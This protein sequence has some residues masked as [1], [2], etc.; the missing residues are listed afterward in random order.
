M[1]TVTGR[2]HFFRLPIEPRR[3]FIAGNAHVNT[4]Q[5]LPMA[6]PPKEKLNVLFAHV[7]YQFAEPFAAR[8]SGIACEI[9]TSAAELEAKIG[10][11]DVLSISGLWRN[12]LIALAPRLKLIQ[13]ISAGTDQYGKEQLKAAGIRLASAHGVNANAVAEHAISLV[14]SLS[15]QLHL[16]RDKQAKREWR[17]MQGNRSIREDEVQGKTV[18][19]VG[20]GRIGARLAE[21]CK[22]FGMTVLAT[23]RNPAT[24][25]GA[26]DELHANS[27]LH[28]LLPRADYV[29]LTCPLTPETEKL[30]G[31]RELAAM[32]PSAS[33]VNVARGKV[34]DEPALIAALE[35][36]QIA[37]AGIDV[38]VE[39]PL[40]AASPLWAMPHVIVTPHTGGETRRYEDR[41]IDLLLENV[42][43][44]GRGDAALVNQIV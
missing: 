7:A 44:L 35:K 20:M 9:A 12:E 43:R 37:G 18:L 42:A 29:V 13:S 6:F 23:K 34:C 28:T 10:S 19:I 16:L 26:A 39:E 14:L 17:P 4:L 25:K 32:K 3:R 8:K 11:A 21:L 36:K 15:R 30:I 31:A 38:T 24:G 1:P 33:L 2:R 27:S 22:A 41:V 5:V 40:P